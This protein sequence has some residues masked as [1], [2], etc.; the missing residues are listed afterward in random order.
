MSCCCSLLNG[1]CSPLKLVC[2]ECAGPVNDGC[3]TEEPVAVAV[4]V[5]ATGCTG[6]KCEARTHKN[7]GGEIINVSFKR[8][9]TPMLRMSEAVRTLHEPHLLLQVG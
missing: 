9:I 8:I 2:L 6:T 4:A 7:I 1:R 5:A 3:T